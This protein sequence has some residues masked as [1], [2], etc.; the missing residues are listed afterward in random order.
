MEKG[1]KNLKDLEEAIN[2]LTP[3]EEYFINF[4]KQ[5]LNGYYIS[6]NDGASILLKRDDK[7]KIN[8]V[9]GGKLRQAITLLMKNYE[10]IIKENNGSVVS[11]C[12]LKSPQSGIIATA[13]N[14][15][16]IKCNLVVFKTKE[17]NANLT[18]ARKEGAVI[19]GSPSGYNSVIECYARKYFPN[20]FFTNM[21]FSAEEII[22]ANVEQVKNIPD[23]LDYLVITVGSAMNLISVIK[24][25]RKYKKNVK[26]IIGVYVGRE[27]FA[28][29]EK[30]YHIYSAL[31]ENNMDLDII[32]YN[33]PY[34]TWVDIDDL[35]FDPIYEAKAYDWLLRNL[36]CKKNKVML[37]VV[38]KRNLEIN[39]ELIT[40]KEFKNT[41]RRLN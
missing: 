22:D 40:F 9:N 20:D 8:N 31:G 3:V 38:G 25:I 32:R 28:T 21:G 15:F 37:W 35:F 13:C 33:K 24:G 12:S 39:P 1:V 19:Y 14:L 34:G 5:K 17:K 16:G 29:L 2:K 30:Y 41:E 36:N 23:D 26:K 6:E 4:K 7:F 18:I 27:P 10:E 11:S